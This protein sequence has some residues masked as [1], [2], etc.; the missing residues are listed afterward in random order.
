MDG[1][2]R[3]IKPVPNAFVINIGDM[4]S[5]ITNYIL[6]A[7][8]HRVMDIGDDRYSS[9]FFFEPHYEAKIPSSILNQDIELTE[10]QK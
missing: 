3:S 10:D 8:L 7:T 4:L 2:W 5:R 1:K 9:P 6:K